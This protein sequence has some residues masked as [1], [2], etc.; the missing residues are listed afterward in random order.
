MYVALSIAF[1]KPA[2]RSGFGRI[3][4]RFHCIYRYL[5]YLGFSARGG[6]TGKIERA[7]KFTCTP[8]L[9]LACIVKN[10]Q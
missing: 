7:A 10:V 5:G 4:L 9:E 2:D 6:D 8:E 1:D 3:R